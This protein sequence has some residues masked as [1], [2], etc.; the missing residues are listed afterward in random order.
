LGLVEMTR[1]NVTDGLFGTMTEV[2]PRCNGQGRVLSAAT[3][4]I[5]VERRLRELLGSA[6]SSAFLFGVHPE[7]YDLLMAPG[8]NVIAALKSE[9]GKQVS[10]VPDTECEPLQ[11][12]VLI[13]GKS[14]FLKRSFDTLRRR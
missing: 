6:G 13:E 3:R 12:K 7:T 11:V 5:A 2:C 8:A 1:K 4:R 10:I 14:G 9:T